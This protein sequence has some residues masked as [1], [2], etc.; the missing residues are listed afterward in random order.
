MTPIQRR[1]ATETLPSQRPSR[2]APRDWEML[3][4]HV[5]GAPYEQIAAEHDLS[6]NHTAHTVRVASYRTEAFLSWGRCPMC[7]GTGRAP[8]VTAEP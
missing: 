7:E 3:C 6:V 1:W 5:S 2:V 4:A 8:T